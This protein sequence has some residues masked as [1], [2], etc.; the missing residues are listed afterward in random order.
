MPDPN[1]EF[2]LRSEIT[3]F[4]DLPWGLPFEQWPGKCSRLEEVPHGVS[5]HPVLFVNYS[6]H[7]FALKEMPPQVAAGEY[8]LLNRLEVLRLPAV[9]PVGLV[10][11]QTSFGA[12]GV[13]ITRYLDQSLPYRT[14]FQ[15]PG[16]VL[17]RQHLLDAMAGL[18]VQLHLAGV[19][20][21]DCS[22]SNTLFRRDAGALRAY[23]VDAE[24]SEYFPKDISPLLRFQDLEIMEENVNGELLDL[25]SLGALL[26]PADVASGG[27]GVPGGNTGAYIRLRY[28]RLW[29]EITREDIIYPEEYYRIQERIRSLNELGFSVGDVALTPTDNGDQLRLRVVVTDRN[30]HQLQLYGLTGLDAE[31]MQARQMMNEV[32]E[33]KA[34]LS[35]QNNRST[36]L[37]V[38]AYYWL[39]KVYGPVVSRLQPLVD[40]HTSP[41]ELYCQVLENK[42]YL[43]EHSC[44]DVGHQAATDDYLLRFGK[45]SAPAP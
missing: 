14:L 1:P 17:Y 43:S 38:A 42:W 29:E 15:Q 28:Q 6:G 41:A 22:L 5:R 36:P 27:L 40:E 9:T 2:I 10:T 32:H 8:E 34:I 26:P 45:K 37:S 13:L 4:R 39:E 25:Q 18:L 21:G 33:I 31:E 11:A 3:D 23:L 7:L 20:W 24:T 12:A 44:R 35:R 30:F 19:Y 16:L